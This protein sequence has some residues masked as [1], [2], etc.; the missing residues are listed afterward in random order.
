MSEA[1][2]KKKTQF[3]YH[4]NSVSRGRQGFSLNGSH[5]SQGWVGQDLRGRTLI[6][7]LNRGGANRGHG[8]CLGYYPQPFVFPSEIYSTEN[9]QIVK[10]SVLNTPGMIRERFA[11]SLRPAPFTSVKPDDNH[12]VGDQGSYLRYLNQWT[13]SSIEQNCPYDFTNS[14]IGFICPTSFYSN[15]NYNARRKYPCGNK[16]DLSKLGAVDS[17]MYILDYK[18]GCSSI[19]SFNNFGVSRNSCANCPISASTIY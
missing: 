19:D 16:S 2:L 12:G 10:S 17:S 8:G 15:T 4:V 7:T 14:S 5:R 18:S 6:R 3:N 1:T 9:T 13:I 11:W